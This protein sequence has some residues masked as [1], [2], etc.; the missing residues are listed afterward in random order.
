LEADGCSNGKAVPVQPMTAHGSQIATP[1]EP[2][3]SGGF[4]VIELVVSMLVLSVLAASIAVGWRS[5]EGTVVYQAQL[6]ARNI[7][8]AQAMA[9][10]R[11]QTLTIM[12][13]GDRYRVRD[14]S[15]TVDD[16]ATGAAFEVLLQHGVVIISGS[17]FS[18]DSLG[19]PKS[20]GFITSNPAR[21]FTLQGGSK[22]A[23]VT[24]R[25]LT[26]FVEV[27]F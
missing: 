8:H 9:L 27:S 12:P 24:V 5:D 18:F 1:P 21:S 7:R 14:T 2:G 3:P 11:G 26:G 25:P 10:S 17:S 13:A 15:G 19:R 22:S 16:P 20:G 23:T 6:F 4:T